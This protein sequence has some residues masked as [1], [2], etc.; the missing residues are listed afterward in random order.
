MVVI[1]ETRRSL[2]KPRLMRAYGYTPEA[3]VDFIEGSVAAAVLVDGDPAFVSKCRD[4]NDHHVIATAVAAAATLIVSG[5]AD[6]LDLGAHGPIRI[7]TPR[8]FLDML[9]EP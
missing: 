4:P 3:I 1:E 2:S 8:Q 9:A 6:L 5:D 7:F